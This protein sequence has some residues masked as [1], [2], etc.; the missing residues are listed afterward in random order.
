M[1]TKE[2]IKYNG[3]KGY[4]KGEKGVS[5]VGKGRKKNG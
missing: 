3:L 5:E 1:L 2:K 4:G